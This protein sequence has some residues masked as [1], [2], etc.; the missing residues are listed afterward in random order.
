MENIL[1]F[2]IEKRVPVCG[3][4]S[5]ECEAAYAVACALIAQDRAVSVIVEND[6]RYVCIFDRHNNPYFLG[7]QDCQC[8]LFDSEAFVIAENVRFDIVL[9]ALQ[10]ILSP[11]P[12]ISG[13]EAPLKER[14]G[15]V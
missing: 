14:G 5:H 13:Q 4:S 8:Y 1:R 10:S 6:G 12:A 7:R 11:D 3:L 15:S 2:P 9:D